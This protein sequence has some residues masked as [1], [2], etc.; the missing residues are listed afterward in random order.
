MAAFLLNPSPPFRLD[1][2]VWV[3][4]RLPINQMDQWDGQMYRRVLVL[5]G[6][7]VA[8]EVMQSAAPQ[9]PALTVTVRGARLGSRRQEYLVAALEKIL[10]LKV[11]LS[12][13]YR[14][15]RQD[16]QLAS[17]VDPFLGFRP[18]RL[19]SVFETLL[20]GIAC[21]QVS[22]AAGMHL[23]NRLCRSFGLAVGKGH[24]F[25]R[26]TDL[27]RAAPGDLRALGFSTRKAQALLDIAHAVAKDELD[28]EGLSAMDD[29]P[30]LERLMAL[31]GDWA[32]GQHN[33][34]CFAAWDGWMFSPPTMWA[35]R[36]RCSGGWDVESGPITRECTV[37]SHPGGHTG[38]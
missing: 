22:L 3:L 38:V 12:P 29:E 13:F 7:A 19:P 37:S 31:K 18:P 9:S 33:T 36:A 24:A 17:L 2:T 16:R 28:L 26:P 8:V 6:T 20:N 4:R 11:D 23:L 5:E 30:A 25:P 35:A 10:G 32:L 1:L 21:Q 27:A 14:I 15:A 34:P